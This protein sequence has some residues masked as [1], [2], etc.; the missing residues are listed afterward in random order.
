M[1]YKEAMKKY[2][3]THYGQELR[4]TEHMIRKMEWQLPG[5]PIPDDFF[6]DQFMKN[7]QALAYMFFMHDS[8][9]DS[10]RDLNRV[11]LYKVNAWVKKSLEDLKKQPE[12]PET[13]NEENEHI[14]ILLMI[15]TQIGDLPMTKNKRAYSAVFIYLFLVVCAIVLC[16]YAPIL[17][18]PLLLLLGWFY[19]SLS[20][21]KH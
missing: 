3:G 19:Y 6:W 14:K 9:F 21:K 17:G 7:Q 12:T 16:I 1:T 8:N 4:F 15:R 5:E 20:P 11:P 13:E 2:A 10:W 18:V